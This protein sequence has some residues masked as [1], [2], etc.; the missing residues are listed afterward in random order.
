MN[1]FSHGVSFG[2]RWTQCQDKVR[3]ASKGQCWR[4]THGCSELAGQEADIQ[5]VWPFRIPMIKIGSALVAGSTRENKKMTRV[6]RA[7]LMRVVRVRIHI[8][9]VFQ[10]SS[11]WLNTAAGQGWVRKHGKSRVRFYQRLLLLKH[12]WQHHEECQ[13]LKSTI[14]LETKNSQLNCRSASA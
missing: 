3:K 4:V 6:K 13:S 7:S 12:K 5:F 10:Q 2:S 8:H 1:L 11:F 14:L 9:S